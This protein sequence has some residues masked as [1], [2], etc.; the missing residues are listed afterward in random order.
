VSNAAAQLAAPGAPSWAR[1]PALPSI[2]A[3]V[4]RWPAARRVRPKRPPG[5]G[6][7]G[8][9]VRLMRH[10][11]GVRSRRRG[12]RV[13][14]V[15]PG[16]G[17]RRPGRRA[18]CRC[19]T[20][21][22]RCWCPTR[23]VSC[24]RRP[25]RLPGRERL[26]VRRHLDDHRGSCARVR[27]GSPGRAGTPLARGRSAHTP[28]GTAQTGRS[29]V[30][31]ESGQRNVHR[32]THDN[33][34]GGQGHHTTEGAGHPLHDPRARPGVVREHRRCSMVQVHNLFSQPRAA[35]PCGQTVAARVVDRRACGQSS[36]S[37]PR[38]GFQTNPL[39]L[40]SAYDL[41]ALPG[42]ADPALVDSR[43]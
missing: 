18:R 34:A 5:L 33:R 19:A 38:A 22:A 14:L 23:R 2:L 32:Q 13:R 17:V 37:L 11:L 41:R 4:I 25:V 7:R 26:G 43:R 1:P 16:V 30:S 20:R 39:G 6:Q 36:E 31:T 42:V 12:L 15:R 28:M 8:V 3:V 29:Q 24:P 21:R 40:R 35:T 9:R 10:G 27:G